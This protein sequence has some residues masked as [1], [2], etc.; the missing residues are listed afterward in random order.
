MPLSNRNQNE[1]GKLRITVTCPCCGGACIV[2]SST[3]ITERIREQY[4]QCNNA[5]C[6]WSGVAITEVVR[7][8]SEPSRFYADADVPP[9]VEADFFD[10]AS[11]DDNKLI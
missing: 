6:G 2:R 5:I 8:I 7:T 3:R 10:K 1:P 11:F 4:V 9:L